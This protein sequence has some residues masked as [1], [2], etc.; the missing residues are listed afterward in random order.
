MMAPTKLYEQWL[1]LQSAHQLLHLL[2]GGAVSAMC[3]VAFG[4]A[5]CGIQHFREQV[6]IADGVEEDAGAFQD[7]VNCHVDVLLIF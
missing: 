6:D 1:H 3:A 7:I 4:V 5:A 2:I